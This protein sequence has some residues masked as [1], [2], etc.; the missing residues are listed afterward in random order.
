MEL[1]AFTTYADIRT[2]LGISS[3]ELPDEDLALETYL[4]GLMSELEAVSPTLESDYVVAASAVTNNTA[5]ETQK[6]IY[7][8]ARLFATIQV[9][10]AAAYSLPLR[11]QKSLTDGKAGVSRF[12]GTPYKDTLENLQ[13]LLA[14]ARV[15]LESKYALFT[16][17]TVVATI[18]S[19]LSVVTP[20]V[21]PVT[22]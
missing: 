2:V 19:F 21:D 22:G 3:D 13:I 7:R 5:T 1:T 20:A 9:G 15:S 6:S 10:L 18:P 12:T 8:A 14:Q 4:F 11:A 16:G 17:G